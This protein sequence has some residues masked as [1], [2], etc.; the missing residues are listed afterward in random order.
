MK[1]LITK[2]RRPRQEGMIFL[3]LM[4]VLFVAG[5][6]VAISA[7]NNRQAAS[8]AKAKEVHYQMEA[9]KTALLVYAANY[10][11]FYSDARGPGFFP[12]PDTDDPDADPDGEPNYTGT[13]SLQECT[14]DTP[15]I[16]RLPQLEELTSLTFRFN[17]AFAD[18]DE[19]FWYVVAPRYVYSN[20]TANR[21]S[22]TRTYTGP[23]TLFD[24]ASD[25]WLTLDGTSQYVA[26]IIAPGEE[27]ETQNR[28]AGQTNY[29]NYLD[30]QNGSSFNFYTS[31][32]SNPALFNDQILGITLDEYMAYVGIA[33]AREVKV[34]LDSY[35][36][37]YAFTPKRY[38]SDSGSA[39]VTSTTCSTSTF[40][41]LFDG[42]TYGTANIWLRDSTSGN[43]GERWGCTHGMYWNRDASPD[44]DQGSLIFNG[45]PN[46]YFRIDYT[47]SNIDRIGDSC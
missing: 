11:K 25:Y 5:G 34:R 39:S 1:N 27:L 18:I 31:Y 45:C 37:Q 36:T 3:A 38:P 21:R 33:V 15:A 47:T 40:G 13:P 17:N 41:N 30:G 28:A 46:M 24:Y 2:R 22:Y 7:L 29:A 42:T 4:L 44:Y 35:Y 14:Y 8:I 6:S 26:L 12:C 43:N 10:A 9:A 16:G 32:A 20:T 23:D 19:Q